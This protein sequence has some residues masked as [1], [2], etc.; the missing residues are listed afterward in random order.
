MGPEK[1]RL[2]SFQVPTEANQILHEVLALEHMSMI[3]LGHSEQPP[4]V[5][6][7]IE[8][9]EKSLSACP[10]MPTAAGRRMG[11]AGRAR[12]ILTGPCTHAFLSLPSVIFGLLHHFFSS[13]S[14]ARPAFLFVLWTHQWRLRRLAYT[15]STMLTLVCSWKGEGSHCSGWMRS[16]HR[17]PK[18]HAALQAGFHPAVRAALLGVERIIRRA[19]KGGGGVEAEP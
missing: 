3:A 12:R 8:A 1:T 6:A 2:V 5:T 15:T 7:S 17:L 16:T 10:P 14:R 18:R 19:R 11:V 4:P 13:I 9:D